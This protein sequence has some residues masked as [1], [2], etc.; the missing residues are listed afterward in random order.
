MLKIVVGARFIKIDWNLLFA[1][2]DCLFVN[3][4][5]EHEFTVI[6]DF[7]CLVSSGTNV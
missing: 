5:T 1:G 3:A 2:Y 6:V 4:W 7:S